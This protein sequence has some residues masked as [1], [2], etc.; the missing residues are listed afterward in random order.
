MGNPSD[1][2]NTKKLINFAST[3]KFK[4]SSSEFTR[5][6]DSINQSKEKDRKPDLAKA[7]LV[8]QMAQSEARIHEGGLKDFYG[9]RKKWSWFLFG[10]IAVS[11]IFQ[12]AVTFFVIFRFP[13]FNDYKSFLFL[14]MGEN[15]AQIVG[16]GYIV[17]NFLFRDSAQKK[18]ISENSD[19]QVK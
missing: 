12:M 1:D 16:M 5:I 15:F 6:L 18:P 8:S 4:V 3:S 17:V 14:I 13:N 19:K 11:I 9:L 10:F 7:E 2:L